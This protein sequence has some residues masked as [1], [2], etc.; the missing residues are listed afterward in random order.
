[1]I[2]FPCNHRETTITKHQLEEAPFPPFSHPLPLLNRDAFLGTRWGRIPF[3]LNWDDT[4]MHDMC[5]NLA[6][7]FCQTVQSC[8]YILS[9]KTVKLS[10]LLIIRY[11]CLPRF[12]FNTWHSLNQSQKRRNITCFRND[13]WVLLTTSHT[14]SHSVTE[15][16]HSNQLSTALT[17]YL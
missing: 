8:L 9:A 7:R 17:G 6:F 15:G 1:M 5:D 10:G 4:I 11:C 2:G 13:I 3:I 12:H 16:P 14:S